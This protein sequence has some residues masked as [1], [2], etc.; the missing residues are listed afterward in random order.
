MHASNQDVLDALAAGR[1]DDSLTEK[2]ESTAA[3]VIAS[4]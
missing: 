1:L 2:I 4:M 3:A